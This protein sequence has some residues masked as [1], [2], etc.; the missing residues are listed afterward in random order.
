MGFT[1]GEFGKY[2][3][4]RGQGLV[5]QLGYAALPINLVLAGFERLRN[6]PGAQVPQATA[7]ILGSCANPTFATDGTNTLAQLDPQPQPCDRQGPTQCTTGTTQKGQF[8]G[9]RTLS[10]VS[11]DGSAQPSVSA[12]HACPTGTAEATLSLITHSGAEVGLLAS[13]LDAATVSVPFSGK[14]GHSMGDVFRASG[15]T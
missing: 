7:D 6:V 10:P 2:L 14:V 1:L 15:A 11:G 12:A 4:C 9:G 5:N 8:P 13:P 3:L